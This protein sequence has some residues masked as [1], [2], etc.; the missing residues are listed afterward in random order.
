MSDFP[1]FQNNNNNIRN[2]SMN[3]Q[4]TSPAGSKEISRSKIF[5]SLGG[6]NL[7][8]SHHDLNNKI[9]YSNNG[10]LSGLSKAA[11]LNHEVIRKSNTIKN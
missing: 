9:W 5:K 10:G 1:T 4:G 8:D 6:H 11:P 2:N 7:G 3:L